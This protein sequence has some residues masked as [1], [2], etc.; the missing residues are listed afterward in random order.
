M[1]K[2][3]IVTDSTAYIPK[4]YLERYPI[5]VVPQVLIWDGETLEDGVDILP[6][7]FYT[8][9]A[10]SKTMPTTSQVSV[11]NMQKTFS[12]LLEEG[13][14]VLG[15]FISSKLSGTLQSAMQGRASLER[16]LEKIQIHDTNSTVMA[17]GFQVLA[18]ARAAA[19]GASLAECLALAEHA[20]ATT[21]V[22]FV[23][24]SLDYLHRGGRIGG[25][26]HL[27]GTAL[28]LKPILKLNDG[29]VESAEKVRTKSKAI[30]RMIGLVVE[31]CQ[32]KSPV[33]LSSLHANAPEQ[34]QAA[35]EKAASRLN[36]T[37]IIAS[38][39]SPVIG[40]HT[41]PGTVGIAYMAGL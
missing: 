16:G 36:V 15:M 41:G 32:G 39:L 28:N 27:L 2:V 31:Q 25:A 13:Y 33:H 17:M 23:V 22:Y 8:R 12:A 4:T 9:L 19:E 3:A 37:E 14:E 10:A 38:E 35:V 18:V 5:R 24:D 26:A 7:A 34:A 30:E 40:N 1:N 20:K 29:R 21:N 11:L 6:G